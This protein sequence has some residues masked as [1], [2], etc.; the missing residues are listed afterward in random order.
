MR[1]LSLGLSSAM[2]RVTLTD[3]ATPQIQ[4]IAM[5]LYH[6]RI[7]ERELGTAPIDSQSGM[8]DV[9][10]CYHARCDVHHF[11]SHARSLV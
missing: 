8:M 10:R 3:M 5:A 9:Q 7:P 4:K 11:T 2:V 6:R 1:L